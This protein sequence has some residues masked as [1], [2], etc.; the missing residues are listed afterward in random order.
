M[1]ARSRPTSTCRTAARE[2]SR[3]EPKRSRGGC[4]DGIDVRRGA[5]AA[6]ARPRAGGGPRAGGLPYPERPRRGG[7]PGGVPRVGDARVG[8]RRRRAATG[9]G[10][11]PQRRRARLARRRPDGGPHRPHGHEAG[12]PRVERDRAVLGGADRRGGLRPRRDGHEG[13]ARLPD[14]RD[15][16]RARV[17]PAGSRPAGDGRGLRPHGRPAGVDRVLRHASG[18]PLRARRAHRQPGVPGASRPVLL[19]R[20]HA[21]SLGA[22]VPQ[23]AGDQRERAGRAGGPGAGRLE[24]RA[25]S[26]AVGGRPVRCGDLRRAGAHLRR[27]RARR[28]LDDPGRV[29]DPRGLPAAAGRHDRGGPS[30]DRSLPRGGGGCRPPLPRPTSCSPT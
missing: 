2:R 4:R 8:V 12:V 16:G 17:R 5:R 10:G 24:V 9:G 22:H 1:R 29:R 23:A 18:R 3:R 21:R 11:P 28:P 14:R 26:G 30:R 6:R 13:G 20:H 15:R 27:S 19:R 7:R 25:R